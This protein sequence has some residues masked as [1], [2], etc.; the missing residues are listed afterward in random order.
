MNLDSSMPQA[1]D[2]TPT[3]R[4]LRTLGDIPFRAWQC[5][6]ELMDNS[7]DAFTDAEN[8]GKVIDGPRV[9]IH[10]SNDSVP[11][12]DREIIVEDNGPGMELAVLQ[13][14]AKAG[15]SN[16]DPIH[17]LGLFGM[18]FN[19][20]TARLG[21][22]TIFLS[23]TSESS[24]WVGIKINF[25]Q[26]IKAQAFS[27]PVVREPKKNPDESGTK[28][29]VRDLKEGVFAEIRKKEGSIRRQLEI[30]YTPILG[31]NKVLVFIQGKQLSPHAHCV[32]G[33][34]RFVI[35]RGVKVEAIQRINR[36]LG[37]TYFDTYR[38]RYVSDDEAIEIDIAIS[39]GGLAADNI[40]RRSRRLKGWLG[41][42]RYSDLTDFGIDFIRNGRKILVSDKSLFGYENPDTGTSIPEYP[43]ELGSTVGG[44]IVGELYV[45]YLIPTYQKNAFDTTD[46]AWRLTVEAIRGAGPILPKKRQE[47]GYDGDNESPL[48]RL[49][50]AYRRADPGT[51]NLSIPNSVAREFYKRF[52]AGDL[53][54]QSDDKCYRVAQEA[55]REQGEG[56]R[57]LTPVNIGDVPSDDVASYLPK[58]SVT[59]NGASDNSAVS[60]KPVAPVAFI[61]S[62]ANSGRDQLIQGSEKE[63]TLSGSYSP[64]TTPGMEVTAWRLKDGQIKI[65]GVRVPCHF[66]QDGIEVDFFYDQT[67][68]VLSE[69]PLSPKQLLLQGLA[70]KF[71]LRDPGVSIQSAFFGLVDNHMSEERINPQALQERAYS[72][73]SGIREKLPSLLGHRFAKV[74]QT[75]QSVASEEANLAKK[76]LDE[77]PYLLN[78][79]QDSNEEAPR[80]LAFVCD[81]TI[82]R[83]IAEFPEEFLD[84]KLFAQPYSKLTIG[85]ESLREELRRHSLE[86][87]L[88]YFSDVVLLLQGGRAQS[89]QELL[90]HANTLSLLEGLLE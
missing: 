43:V 25:E 64:D 62:P 1:V 49:V 46:R 89:K 12:R 3:P 14:A 63:E 69:Y 84:N 71:A 73:V 65:Q 55:D 13:N 79:Y 20:A 5:L 48:A 51:K 42:Q 29:I 4:I 81:A 9:D 11:A 70:E 15:Y 36:D 72:I 27:A 52:V 18:G 19:I 2:I 53:E 7:L 86:R 74:K 90:R 80:S 8:K 76:L 57:G 44:R 17:N 24:E 35:R 61:L 26:L 45:D 85:D 32:W 33:D 54:Y 30:I 23:T 82:K 37:E 68:P 88:L 87:I 60:Q 47:H 67:H 39:K 77:A 66:F 41:I 40:V 59:S 16:N 34:S 31:K 10:W 83:L 78:A 50:N 22:E 28:I 21:D 6:A 38:N 75:I 56:A 58:Q